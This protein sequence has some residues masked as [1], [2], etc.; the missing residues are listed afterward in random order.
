MNKL[1]IYVQDA[2][3]KYKS[4]KLENRQTEAS[5][6][7]KMEK[8]CLRVCGGENGDGWLNK[9][10]SFARAHAHMTYDTP[11]HNKQSKNNAYNSNKSTTTTITKNKT[12]SNKTPTTKTTV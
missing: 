3:E 12:L 9:L 10:N 8:E 11:I 7:K 2:S 4:L 5:K 1:N 6:E